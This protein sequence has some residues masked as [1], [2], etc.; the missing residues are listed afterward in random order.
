[1]RIVREGEESIKMRAYLSVDDKEFKDLINGYHTWLV[2][3][4]SDRFSIHKLHPTDVFA[5][6]KHRG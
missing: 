3:W 5:V 2:Y 6:E 4:C 1:M